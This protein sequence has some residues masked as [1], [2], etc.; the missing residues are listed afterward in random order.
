MAAIVTSNFRFLNAENFKSDISANNM[1]IGIGKTDA[2]SDSTSDVTDSAPPVP[3]D[4]ID[5]IN[6]A[7]EQLV[8]ITKVAGG[9]VSNVVP[10]HNWTA[11]STYVP[12]DSSDS[13]I[14]DRVFY[15]I[16]SEFKI[17]KLVGVSSTATTS[18]I[19][20]THTDASPSSDSDGYNWKY[21]YTLGTTDVTNFL[22]T[23]YMPV[24]TLDISTT[25]ASQG[26]DAFDT[27][28]H[29]AQDASGALAGAQG[30][31]HIKVTEVGSGYTS[32]TIGITGDGT[33][34]T[35]TANI[36]GGQITS[37]TVNTIGANYTQTDVVITGDGTG[38]EAVAIIEPGAGHGTDPVKELG[39]FF[40]S[41]RAVLDGASGD[42]TVANDFRQICLI[43]NPT[44]SSSLI[45]ADTVQTLKAVS[46]SGNAPSGTFVK[47]EVLTGGTSGAQAF[48]A[49][50]DTPGGLIYYTQNDKTGY[51][52]FDASETVT[53]TGGATVGLISVSHAIAPSFDDNS[54][55][56]I[57]LENRDP[58]RRSAS[59]IEDIKLIIEF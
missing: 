42:I 9:S 22:T 25:A 31:Q 55:K 5:E 15:V 1:Y 30:V 23:S 4:T 52:E 20:P 48:I 58:I 57:F 43:K 29:G 54:G 44:F 45:T 24:K 26:L 50:V 36:V 12:W 11:G 35:A 8:G 28:Q 59:Q 56:M 16:T 19:Q 3:R 21:M 39:G 49:Y 2:W 32:A 46:Y 14:Y 38:A 47:D 34:A 41:L 13:L 7:Y 6:E 27:A 18:T 17:Y 40:V 53:S 10:R 33:G 37:I 51:E